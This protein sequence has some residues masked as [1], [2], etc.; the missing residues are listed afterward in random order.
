MKH[1]SSLKETSIP[2]PHC[3]GKCDYVE[4]IYR[5]QEQ[6]LLVRVLTALVYIAGIIVIVLMVIVLVYGAFYVMLNIKNL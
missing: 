5:T 6:R 1:L 2:K 4:D 3:F